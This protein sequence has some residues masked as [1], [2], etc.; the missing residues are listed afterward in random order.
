MAA[1]RRGAFAAAL[2]NFALLVNASLPAVVERGGRPGDSCA[3][4]DACVD[5]LCLGGV[6]CIGGGSPDRFDGCLSCASWTTGSNAHG[7]F[8][9]PGYCA[10]C[11]DGMYVYGATCS[12]K[13][14]VGS[15]CN[16]DKYDY[17]CSGLCR[18]DRCCASDVSAA[19]AACN[20]VG[21]CDR[22]GAAGAACAADA[23]CIDGK[24][25]GGACCMGKVNTSTCTKCV[26]SAAAKKNK[27]GYLVPAGACFSCADGFYGSGTGTCRQKKAPGARC[28]NDR[29]GFECSGMCKGR[30]CCA[31]DVEP[32]CPACN[33]DGACDYRGADGAP[34]A[35]GADC[36]DGQCLGGFCCRAALNTTRCTRCVSASVKSTEGGYVTYAGSCSSCV[37]GYYVSR[38]G[39]RCI[40]EKRPGETCLNGDF[41][42]AGTCRTG[43]NGYIDCSGM[44]RASRCCSLNV[45]PKC[46]ACGRDGACAS[47]EEDVAVEMEF[48]SAAARAQ[49][50]ASQLLLALFFLLGQVARPYRGASS[51][52]ECR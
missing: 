18:G 46:S 16:N 2:V 39:T 26:A 47:G 20:S 19:C 9:I 10:R 44:C 6:C 41:E 42:C 50:L 5:G 17:E 48:E 25:L 15:V 1:L 13:K 24:C 49:L 30:R 40:A 22:R 29:K 4:N 43:A 31:A 27:Y 32:N 52:S 3:S 38:D 45:N 12:F 14:P 23:D 36:I 34:C 7:Y 28:Y 37:S 35:T 51:C 33:V 21:A 8:A 11:R